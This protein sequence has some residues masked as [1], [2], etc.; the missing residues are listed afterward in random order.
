MI[1]CDMCMHCARFRNSNTCGLVINTISTF[2]I[3]PFCVLN[4]N[5]ELIQINFAKAPFLNRFFMIQKEALNTL[6]IY[7]CKLEQVEVFFQQSSEKRAEFA[8]FIYVT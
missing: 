1:Q 5:H 2:L 4:N 7:M 3:L 8:N 6:N